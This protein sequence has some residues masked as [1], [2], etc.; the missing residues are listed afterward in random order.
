M[1]EHGRKLK[2]NF[3]RGTTTMAFKFQGGIIVAVDSRASS[4]QYIGKNFIQCIKNRK[5]KCFI[6]F[7]CIEILKNSF[8]V[9]LSINKLFNL[10]CM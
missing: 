3:A 6:L 4:G 2:L 8:I 5:Y 1:D 10:F 7:F 9:I